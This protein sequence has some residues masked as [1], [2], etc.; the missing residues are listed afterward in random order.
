MSAAMTGNAP[1]EKRKARPVL[2]GRDPS[3]EK[4]L[5]G[6]D[7]DG[8]DLH[9]L[10]QIGKR[11]WSERNQWDLRRRRGMFGLG[12]LS[13]AGAH[14]AFDHAFHRQDAAR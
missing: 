13:V 12:A 5:A 10:R 2:T 6:L 3:I 1:P 8:T 7:F 14:R 4:L 11:L 9:D